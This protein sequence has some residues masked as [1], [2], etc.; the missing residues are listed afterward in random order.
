MNDDKISNLWY[1]FK[2]SGYK[3][4]DNIEKSEI[5]ELVVPLNDEISEILTNAILKHINF[6]K[7]E[8][9]DR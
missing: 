3:I 9:E 2:K 7:E 5:E 8:G 1:E 4:P 6:N